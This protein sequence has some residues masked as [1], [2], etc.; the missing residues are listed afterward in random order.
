MGLSDEL[1]ALVDE[2]SEEHPKYRRTTIERLVMRTALEM[3]RAGEVP[4]SGIREAANRQLTYTDL[5]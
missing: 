4:L 2:L 3:R 5:S 1:T